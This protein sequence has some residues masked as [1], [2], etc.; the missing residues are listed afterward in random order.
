MKENERIIK[1][2]DDLYK[3]NPWLDVT[4]MD[5]LKILTPEQAARKMHPGWNSIW[6][7]VDHLVNWRYAMLERINGRVFNSPEDN[8]IRPITDTSAAAW[9]NTLK[10]LE[11]SQ[12]KW[13]DYLSDI[14][15]EDLEKIPDTRPFSRYELIHGILQH[16]AYHLGQIRIL[17]K[18][19]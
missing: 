2:F 3:G 13:K 1:L 9:S 18:T 10:N 17:S 4:I 12:Q 7:V 15:E 8:F 6:Q 16:D 11:D 5:T 14:S 19:I